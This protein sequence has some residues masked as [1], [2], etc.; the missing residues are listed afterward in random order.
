M[1]RLG[2][3]EGHSELTVSP[4]NG[5]ISPL[6]RRVINGGPMA[7]LESVQSVIVA[8]NS[9]RS[10][11][12][13]KRQTLRDAG[14]TVVDFVAFNLHN[15]LERFDQARTKTNYG[16]IFITKCDQLFS[17][18][19]NTLFSSVEDSVEERKH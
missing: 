5:T 13:K 12:V 3:Y 9:G 15:L 6:G 11:V 1:G 16:K 14:R 8:K 10:F 19:N 18:L 17:K 2:Q 7:V 4:S